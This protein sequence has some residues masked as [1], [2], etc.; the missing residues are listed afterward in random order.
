MPHRKS[1]IVSF[2]VRRIRVLPASQTLSPR[3]VMPLL[4]LHAP[5]IARHALTIKLLLALSVQLVM[6]LLA[7]SLV[8]LAI[9]VVMVHSLKVSFAS[10]AITHVLHAR[11]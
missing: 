11:R 8:M 5:L 3:T 1:K 6:A 4:V 10:L 9:P 7:E 2:T